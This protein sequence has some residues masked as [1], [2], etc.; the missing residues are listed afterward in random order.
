MPDAWSGRRCCSCLCEPVKVSGSPEDGLTELG[1]IVEGDWSFTTDVCVN[2]DI[3]LLEE[4][5]FGRSGFTY[6]LFIFRSAPPMN[7]CS[8]SI[9]FGDIAGGNCC[10]N[11][12]NVEDASEDVWDSTLWCLLEDICPSIP[13]IFFAALFISWLPDTKSFIICKASSGETVFSF[14]ASIRR[15]ATGL[16]AVL[17][18]PSWGR[19]PELGCG[20]ALGTCTGTFTS[21]GWL[22]SLKYTWSSAKIWYISTLFQRKFKTRVNEL[23]KIIKPRI[24][25]KNCLRNYSF[26]YGYYSTTYLIHLIKTS[27]R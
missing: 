13:S 18:W 3:S 10:E 21:A 14:S 22:L 9:G 17:G 6:P 1:N 16:I 7:L 20:R 25:R 23:Q 19:I 5:N 4:G 15:V 24:L 2:G 26:R 8:S 11:C 12:E 27:S